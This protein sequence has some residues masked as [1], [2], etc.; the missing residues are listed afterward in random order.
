MTIRGPRTLPLLAALLTAAGPAA[1]PPAPP[2]PTPDQVRAAD[3]AR[4]ALAAGQ[5]AAQQRAADLAAQE[6]RIGADLAAAA[7]RLQGLEQTSADV[8]ERV[9]NLAL[10]QARA[11]AALQRESAALTPLLPAMQRLALYPAETLLAAPL[12]PDD[13]VRGLIVLGGLARTLEAQAAGIQRQQADL[14]RLGAE[15]DRATSDLTIRQL[16]QAKEAQA[17]D[18]QLAAARTQRQAAEDDAA[19]QARKAAAEA[20]RADGLRAAIAKLDAE[21]AAAETKRTRTA[22]AAPVPKSSGAWVVPV[23]GTQLHAFGDEVEGGTATGITYQP[24][25]LARVVSP[26]I[27][28]VVYAGAFRS[29][30][31]LLIV[32][33]GGGAHAVLSGFDRLDIA[34]GR[35]VQAGEPVGAMPPWD[36]A[37][38]GPRPTL[39]LE[40]HQ[41]GAPA[42][43]ASL[44]RARS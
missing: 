9:A 41:G 34:V 28:R 24:P 25:P 10:Q 42:N 29:Y 19:A 26:C 6:R 35:N 30:G 4:A 18:A 23:A 27:G 14:A 15:L 39:L 17:L 7:K 3:Q 36:P 22:S 21:R 31:L 38:G 11:R 43:P 12:P 5:A 37:S 32:D 2:S 44:L 1:P 20:E 40:L 33:C 8:T 16:A 13:A